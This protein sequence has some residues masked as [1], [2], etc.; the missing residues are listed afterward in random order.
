MSLC[1]VDYTM[2]V[3]F[4]SCQTTLLLSHFITK[5]EVN[6]EKLVNNSSS[7]FLQ[8]P[9]ESILWSAFF[10]VLPSVL[11]SFCCT[12]LLS[13]LLV[14]LFFPNNPTST[15]MLFERMKKKKKTRSYF[16]WMLSCLKPRK[17]LPHIV[18]CTTLLAPS[19][20]L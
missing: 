5:I 15:L 6:K 19:L 7:T 3:S 16:F 20:Q 9:A 12:C 2:S 17:Q 18:F 13:F 11:S 14:L 8:F 10:P 1:S 4:Y